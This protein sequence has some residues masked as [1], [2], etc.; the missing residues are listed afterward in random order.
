MTDESFVRWYRVAVLGGMAAWRLVLFNPFAA[1]GL[2]NALEGLV[3]GVG[4]GMLSVAALALLAA[5]RSARWVFVSAAAGVFTVDVVALLVARSSS[6]S[7][8]GVVVMLAPLISLLTVVPAAAVAG[9]LGRP[10]VSEGW[11]R[12]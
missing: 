3:Y 6:S 9:P 7:T 2:Y 5:R 11:E 10:E 4:L 1:R 12:D 8:A